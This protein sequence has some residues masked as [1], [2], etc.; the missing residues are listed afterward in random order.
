MTHQFALIF[1]KN[2]ALSQYGMPHINRLRGDV[3]MDQ[4]VP[5]LGA[6]T[7]HAENKFSMSLFS[8]EEPLHRRTSPLLHPKNLS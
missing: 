3:K 2:P 1:I 7:L 8:T 6:P 5:T 4:G